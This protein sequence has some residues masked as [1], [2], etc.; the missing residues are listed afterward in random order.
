VA[1]HR[2]LCEVWDNGDCLGGGTCSQDSHHTRRNR[3]DYLSRTGHCECPQSITVISETY[4][5]VAL[6]P[7]PPA[8]TVRAP[9]EVTVPARE[10]A[11]PAV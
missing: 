3:P 11:V 10:P 9:A 8:V 5:P 6:V 2:A 1:R 4:C 7:A